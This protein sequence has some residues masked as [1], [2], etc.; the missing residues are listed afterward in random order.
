M[1]RLISK[2]SA[3]P[4]DIGVRMADVA[5]PEIAVVRLDGSELRKLGKQPLP[6]QL[7]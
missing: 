3:A 7:E 2:Q 1:C 6:Q 5:W 4:A